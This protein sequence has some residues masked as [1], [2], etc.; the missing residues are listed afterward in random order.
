MTQTKQA[1]NEAF[2]ASVLP[3]FLEYVRL[4]AATV[5]G[6]ELATSLQ[7]ISSMQCLQELGGVV[8]IVRVPLSLITYDLEQAEQRAYNAADDADEAAG[9]ANTAAAAANTAAQN[10]NDEADLVDAAVLDIAAEKAAAVAA[11]QNANEKADLASSIWATVKA[12]YES[13]NPAWTTWFNA[14]QSDWTVWFTARQ[15]EWPQWYNGIK[16][17]YETWLAT[18]VAAENARADAELVRER[19]ETTRKSNE[20]SRQSAEAQ[21]VADELERDSHPIKRGDNG[22]WWRWDMSLTPHQYVDTGVLADGGIM[23]PFFEIDPTDG[24]LYMYYVTD[25]ETAR[26]ELNEEDG[27]LYFCPMGDSANANNNNS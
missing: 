27:G 8:K 15:T 22:N 11:A 18:A 2:F 12:W 9:R 17:A 6:V 24:G 21:R 4:H 19:N 23:Y 1:E 10:A 25:V 20:T 14:T 13:V 7:G 26:F 5:E 16:S 3:A